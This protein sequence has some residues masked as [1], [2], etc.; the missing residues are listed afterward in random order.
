MAEA[1][2]FLAAL[3]PQ[4]PEEERM[5]LCA[6]G[7]DP[8]SAPPDAWRP[9]PWRPGNKIGLAEEWN[10]Y[11]AVSS[12]F[13]AAD[14]TWRRR[15]SLFAAGHALMVDDVGT[16]PSAKVDPTKIEL[17]PSAKI[18]TSPGNEQWWYFFDAPE[19]DAARFDA[20]IRAFISKKLLGHDPGMAGVTRVGRLPGFLNGKKKYGG[21]RARLVELTDRA[22]P[23]EDLIERFH[24]ELRG[25]AVPPPFM[26]THEHIRRNRAFL[27][28]WRFLES[29]KMLKR[30]GPDAGGWTEMT[31]PWREFH[32]GA[33]DNGAALAQPSEENGY[34][35]AFRC[36]HGHCAD[37]GW[38][39][40]LDWIAEIAV[41]Q[42]AEINRTAPTTLTGVVKP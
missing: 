3:V 8:D 23:V 10:A 11:V 41:E 25:R 7:G 12:F 31:C 34:W 37:K 38:R 4:L 18:E 26:V 6:F 40:L 14:K 33:V 30:A 20:L 15:K 13:I 29:C 16:G 17:R 35:G 42:M 32:T 21:F 9:R 2:E 39:D 24:L 19:R 28:I 1:K 36:H 22:F 5:I 27:D